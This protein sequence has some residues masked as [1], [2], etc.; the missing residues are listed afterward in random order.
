VNCSKQCSAALTRGSNRTTTNGIP[1][2]S[3][4][5]AAISLLDHAT[6]RRASAAN[7]Y[8]LERNL[9][10]IFQSRWKHRAG[11][12]IRAIS[13]TKDPIRKAIDLYANVSLPRPLA[14]PGHTLMPFRSTRRG[15]L[16]RRCKPANLTA[17][18][19]PASPKDY[20]VG[21][22]DQPLPGPTFLAH[23]RDAAGLRIAERT[24]DDMQTLFL[25]HRS[26]HYYRQWW[27][28][29]G[30]ASPASSKLELTTTAEW[31]RQREVFQV[32]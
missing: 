16:K 1:N 21:G 27:Y 29:G 18:Y 7:Q 15:I 31:D 17:S 23:G 22:R 24:A 19:G 26:P 5:F 28:W 4:V 12:G 10:G 6:A 32:F 13:A 3:T 14:F 20:T 2:R 9:G 25:R 30:E 11:A 8:G